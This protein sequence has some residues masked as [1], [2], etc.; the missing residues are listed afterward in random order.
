MNLLLCI[1]CACASWFSFL[2]LSGLSSPL[3]GQSCAFLPPGGPIGFGLVEVGRFENGLEAGD[4]PMWMDDGRTVIGSSQNSGG[5]Y[6]RG[7]VLI[8]S[9]YTSK[10]SL[11]STIYPPIPEIGTFGAFGRHLATSGPW[12]AVWAQKTDDQGIICMYQQ[13]TNATGFEF[14]TNLVGT[15]TSGERLPD[16]VRGLAMHGRWLAAIR[17]GDSGGA[18]YMYRVNDA[19]VWEEK[20]RL[21]HPEYPT[22]IPNDAKID[23]FGRTLVFTYAASGL[24]SGT[25]RADVWRLD[26]DGVWSYET[27]LV[28]E[29]LT[30]AAH[31]GSGFD[32]AEDLIF[33]SASSFEKTATNG[34]GIFIYKRVNGQWTE[35]SRITA[36][37]LGISEFIGNR[38]AYSDFAGEYL[39][40]ATGNL[41]RMFRRKGDTTEWELIS[42]GQPGRSF[43]DW[44][45]PA[46]NIDTY[47]YGSSPTILHLSARSYQVLTG[48]RTFSAL[49]EH[50]TQLHS[51]WPVTRRPGSLDRAHWTFLCPSGAVGCSAVES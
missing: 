35:E 22:S 46:G 13:T 26:D 30:D 33:L 36:A 44:E 7:A 8:F 27:E 34:G 29:G 11:E 19:G 37:G 51:T 10:F 39:A 40:E 43:K 42:R 1:R 5:G 2:L 12:L 21:I 15:G 50:G 6:R 38:I 18:I 25:G 23:I 31:L 45:S 9:P 4:S 41:M 48:F 20:Q 24:S 49:H 16:G 32:V 17:Y 14:R 47:S 28:P 3:R